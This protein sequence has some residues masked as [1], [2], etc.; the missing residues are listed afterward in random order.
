MGKAKRITL[1]TGTHFIVRGTL[2]GSTYILARP[3][4]D[5]L[6]AFSDINHAIFVANYCD[7]RGGAY[8]SATRKA[9]NA[10]AIKEVQHG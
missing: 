6:D 2:H 10:A 1:H 8:D 9:A 7:E 5:S 3:N 4:G